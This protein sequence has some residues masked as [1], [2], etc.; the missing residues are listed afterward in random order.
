VVATAFQ[1]QVIYDKAQKH[2]NG[3]AI[4][5]SLVRKAIKAQT[6]RIVGN[7]TRWKLWWLLDH[8]VSI[9]A[10]ELALSG[11]GSE[12]DTCE[13]GGGSGQA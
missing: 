4:V 3:E 13:C 8:G 10:I 12:D 7:D 6:Q 9:K 1:H 2:P 11:E 5:H